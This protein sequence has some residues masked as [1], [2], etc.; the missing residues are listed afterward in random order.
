MAFKY[1]NTWRDFCKRFGFASGWVVLILGLY[2]IV[3][4]GA[5][6]KIPNPTDPEWLMTDINEKN[7]RRLFSL[8]PSILADTWSPVIFGTVTIMAHYEGEELY[9]FHD[10]TA[11]HKKYLVWNVFMLL[12]G[13]IGYDGLLG[14]LVACVVIIACINCIVSI[15]LGDSS[16]SLALRLN[17]CPCKRKKASMNANLGDLSKLEEEGYGVGQDAHGWT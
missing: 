11:N 12:F 4:I 16:A 14:I 13:S 8:D 1:D 17:D 7:W 10:I 2:H 9:F 5:S 3:T 15:C 6:I